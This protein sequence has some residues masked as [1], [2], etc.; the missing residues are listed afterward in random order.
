M[1]SQM[2]WKTWTVTLWLFH[3]AERTGGRLATLCRH[4]EK[5]RHWCWWTDSLICFNCASQLNKINDMSEI[6]LTIEQPMTPNEAESWPEISQKLGQKW[7]KIV[8]CM[9]S[10]GVCT[11]ASGKLKLLWIQ[12][13][14]KQFAS[15]ED[16][17]T[18]AFSVWAYRQ[19]IA[20]CVEIIW[21]ISFHAKECL[22]NTHRQHVRQRLSQ[23]YIM[24]FLWNKQV[25]QTPDCVTFWVVHCKEIHLDKPFF[26]FLHLLLLFPVV[27]P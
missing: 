12:L 9:P 7:A 18:V 14:V 25:S 24:G 8:Q 10:L 23:E 20:K 6:H 17:L 27:L 3:L 5:K 19:S 15:D 16:S 13:D 4:S 21:I 22:W 26:G 11:H 1:D 2:S